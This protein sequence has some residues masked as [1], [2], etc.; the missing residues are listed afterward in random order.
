MIKFRFSQSALP[1]MLT[2]FCSCSE[3]FCSIMPD[4]E[5]SLLYSPSDQCEY[6]VINRYDA[7]L[8]FVMNICYSRN[9]TDNSRKLF[10]FRMVRRVLSMKFTLSNVKS[11]KLVNSKRELPQKSMT[12]EPALSW[13]GSIPISLSAA[14]GHQNT[15]EMKMNESSRSHF[16]CAL[17]CKGCA[18]CIFNHAEPGKWWSDQNLFRYSVES[19]LAIFWHYGF[20]GKPD[21]DSRRE[22]RESTG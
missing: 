12:L 20:I 15:W 6:S 17:G 18:F 2:D 4:I 3:C 9:L 19:S 14:H 22:N 16:V 1:W 7:I 13:N 11:H 8:N 21:P 10:T 5:C